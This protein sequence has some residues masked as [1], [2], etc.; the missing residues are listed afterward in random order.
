M[1]APNVWQPR[2]FLATAWFQPTSSTMFTKTQLYHRHRHFRHPGA[3][4]MYE[5]LRKTPEVVLSPNLFKMLQEI[6]EYCGSCQTFGS[7]EVTFSS[8]LKGEAIF[9]LH[10][11]LD[12]FYLDS[13]PVIHVTDT[14]TKLER[15]VSLHAYQRIQPQLKYGKRFV[16]DGLLCTL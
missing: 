7:K 13:K 2:L 4:K 12:L 9:N 14:D 11:K 8:P 16:N 15:L 3:A 6:V 10:I 1:V 5:I